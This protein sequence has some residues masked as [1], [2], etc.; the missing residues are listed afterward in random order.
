MPYIWHWLWWVTC[1][2]LPLSKLDPYQIALKQYLDDFNQVLEPYVKHTNQL[3]AVS[4]AYEMVVALLRCCRHGIFVKA[5]C[6]KQTG[7]EG[8]HHNDASL[9]V[10]VFSLT[11][12]EKQVLEMEP[13]LQQGRSQDPNWGCW[14][15]PCHAGRAV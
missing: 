5:F 2:C 4:G 1:C 3:P 9:A 11:P 13:V 6:F 15:L 14:C 10:L 12:E 7:S 8:D